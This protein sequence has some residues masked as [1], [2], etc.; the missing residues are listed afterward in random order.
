MCIGGGGVRLRGCLLLLSCAN[1]HDWCKPVWCLVLVLWFLTGFQN[2]SNQSAGGSPWLKPQKHTLF[3]L[4]ADQSPR[5]DIFRVKMALRSLRSAADSSCKC[6]LAP[7]EE[8][9]CFFVFVLYFRTYNLALPS[10][11]FTWLQILSLSWERPPGPIIKRLTFTIGRGVWVTAPL[12]M[13]RTV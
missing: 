2:E 11:K 1:R 10:R 13:L 12:L 8:Q 3:T 4:A 9:F 7:K 5:P 6:D